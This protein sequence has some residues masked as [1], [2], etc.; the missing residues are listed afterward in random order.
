MILMPIGTII[1][2]MN[3]YQN[4]SVRPL[5]NS[6]RVVCLLLATYLIL[7]LPSIFMLLGINGQRFSAQNWT[8]GIALS[9]LAWHIFFRKRVIHLQSKPRL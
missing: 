6:W 3:G 1:L 5:G 2:I 4:S 9:I 8:I 7:V